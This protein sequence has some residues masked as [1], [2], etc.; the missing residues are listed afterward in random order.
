M[1]KTYNFKNFEDAIEARWRECGIGT[2]ECVHGSGGAFKE[3][4]VVV[5][6]PPNV[7]G[8]LHM[9][10]GLD[11]TIQDVIVRYKRMR[12]NLTTWVPGTDHAG[13][14]TQQVME[15][16]LAKEGKTRAD[17]S[18][19]EFV[20]RTMELSEAH[21]S[22]ILNQLRKLGAS[23]DWSR[24][25]FTLDEGMSRAVREAFV[26]LYERGL[27]YRGDYLVNWSVGIGTAI[28]DDEVEHK[29][30]QGF[31][32]T[33]RYP[34]VEDKQERFIDIATTRPE[35][36]L[37]DVAVAV[38]PD[39]ARYKEAIGKQVR[40][41]LTG[42][43]I[44]IVADEY[45][46]SEFGTGAVKITPAHDYNDYE[47]GKRHGM[48]RISILNG[49][50][51]INENAPEAYR[52][53][54]VQAA[55][56]R[57]VEDLRAQGY[58][59]DVKEHTHSVGHCY[60]TGAVVEPMLSTQWF[61][62][63]RGMADKALAAWEAG[64]VRFHPKHWEN[65]FVHWL[66]NI[67][68]WCISRQL[69]WGHRI[70]VWYDDA[71]GDVIVSRERPEA[72]GRSLRQEGDVL[73]TWFSSWL[74][75]FSVF[76]W[77]ETSK[78][79]QS[80]YPTSVLVTGYDILF[81]WV[82][83]MIMAGLEFVGEVP[84]PDVYLHGLIRDEKGRKMSKS[85]G[86]GIDPLAVI[87]TY[88]A[89]ALRFTLTFLCKLDTDILLREDSFQL[90]SR[91]ANKVWNASRF[92]LMQLESIRLDGAIMNAKRLPS[93]VLNET[94]KWMVSR[95]ERTSAAIEKHMEA[96]RLDEAA[97]DVYEYFWWDFCDWYVEANKVCMA[98]E[99]AAE[100][101]RSASVLMWVLQANLRLLHPFLPFVT[102]EI[103]KTIHVA[104]KA[105]G[106]GTRGE[107]PLLALE[108]YPQHEERAPYEEAMKL[109]SA[110]QELVTGVRTLR[111]EFTIAPKKTIRVSV[112]MESD[113]L[114]DYF[115]R[116]K[117]LL[118]FLMHA[119]VT[120]GER[121]ASNGIGV[122]GTGFSASVYIK[123]SIDVE[124]E[125]A[126]LAKKLGKLEKQYASLNAQLTNE[127]FLEKASADYVERVRAQ[128]EDL[129]SSMEKTKK[130]YEQL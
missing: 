47:L 18:R 30:V 52:G 126:R 8:T 21:K 62:K 122:T 106:G 101:T 78:D 69:L 64:K 24:E 103:Y 127:K 66:K 97:K 14:A 68:D 39:D 128:A 4:F 104:L 81:F 15:R 119:E 117:R 2:P 54:S 60:R 123:E 12:G 129:R 120:L 26:R 59:I 113:K 86:N 40:L 51:T 96:Y 44:P 35:T 84:F 76:G 7:T 125:R 65:T 74:W 3:A 5:I 6:P 90:G 93:E 50:G 56:K 36:M 82:A 13:I 38:H 43:S 9:G 57:V 83:R 107:T 130:F 92:V 71:S 31:L 33:I 91:F 85:L 55:R 75:P 87:D 49:D 41:P 34:F 42:R 32:Y 20:E 46:K 100:Q 19:E 67:K 1:D 102:E 115:T 116:Q 88:G 112:Y 17:L 95:L 23:C 111:S 79:L 80:F 58:L 27:I 29:E 10:H 25:R 105:K 99:V 63:M 109:F 121:D 89:D 61:V 70:P 72:H 48:E 73:D 45:V 53:L 94:D 28:S 124:V 108:A 16:A 118:E 98:Q 110:L 11:N 114:E 77:P 22:I 37:G